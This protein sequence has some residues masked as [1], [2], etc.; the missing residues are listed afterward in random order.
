M[1]PRSIRHKI[2]TSEPSGA[3]T[4]GAPLICRVSKVIEVTL[5]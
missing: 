2:R 3:M 4:S 5:L 1:L